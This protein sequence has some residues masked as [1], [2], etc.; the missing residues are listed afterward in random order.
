M[1]EKK[2]EACTG[3]AAR[4]S[5]PDTGGRL[6]LGFPTE[7]SLRVVMRHLEGS[8]HTYRYM[9]EEQCIWIIVEPGLHGALMNAFDAGL[10]PEVQEEVRALFL[11]GYDK[12][13]LADFARVAT[14]KE[15][16]IRSQSGWLLD[17]LL[18]ERL[19]SHFQPIVHAHDTSRIFAHEALMRGLEADGRLIFP[20][21]ILDL[22]RRA[23]LI[24]QLDLLARRTAIREARR[25]GIDRHVFINFNP[26]GI[27]DPAVSLR[28]TVQAVDEAKIPRERVVF[29]LVESD[30][31]RDLAHL[32]AIVSYWRDAGFSVA[33]DDLGAGHSTLNLLHQ[34]RP[35]YVKLD[36][37]LIRD[38]HLD[39]Y[40]ALITGKI[41]EI[42]QHLDIQTVAEGVE[43]PEELE[44]VR[45]HGATFVQGYL[46]A[47]PAHPP[48]PSTPLIPHRH[49]KSA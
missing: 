20:N 44:W 33:L 5:F 13:I 15:L 22:A 28:S 37:A 39:P 42:A 31:T 6:F 27:D 11:T 17:L 14:L 32:K 29:E 24:E 46:I 7:R 25:H 4:S 35:D 3:Y 9:A 19:T 49:G 40:K 23:D 38:V 30:H 10:R 2:V 1:L 8:G 26:G 34:L 16:I 41:L 43:V 48:V 36:M 47:K 45:E 18:E 21:Q 12:P